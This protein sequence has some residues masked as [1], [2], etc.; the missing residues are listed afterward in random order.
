MS[1][2]SHA[3]PWS[4]V[5]SERTGDAPRGVCALLRVCISVR[6]CLHWECSHRRPV[7]APLALYEG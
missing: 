6:E 5:L 7:N 3:R 4:A 1:R 2:S